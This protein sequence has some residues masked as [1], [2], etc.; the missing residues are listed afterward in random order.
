MRWSDANAKHRWHTPSSLA[1]ELNDE[2]LPNGV[3][4]KTFVSKLNR[5]EEGEI[6]QPSPP[7]LQPRTQRGFF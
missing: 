4:P 1:A 5:I 6:G 7:L 3:C 2:S